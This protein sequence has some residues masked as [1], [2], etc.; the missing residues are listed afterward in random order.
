MFILSAGIVRTGLINAITYRILAVAGRSQYRQLLLITAVVGSISGFIND[1]AAVAILLPL[2]L[3]V[4]RDTPAP[5]PRSSSSPSPT[6][7]SSA[8]P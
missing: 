5:V 7:P 4:A 2:V 6:R 1:T 8:A 3:G